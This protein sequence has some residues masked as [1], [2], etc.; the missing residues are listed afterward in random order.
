MRAIV[1]LISAMLVVPIEAASAQDYLGSYLD[2]QR[3]G[4]LREHQQRTRQQRQRERRAATPA[5]ARH[6][7]ACQ[8]AYRSYNARTDRYVVR[9]GV[10]ARCRL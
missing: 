10:T 6:I 8:R 3:W 7:R 9:P 5:A 4:N 1:I 2:A